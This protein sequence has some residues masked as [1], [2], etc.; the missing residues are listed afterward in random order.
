MATFTKPCFKSNTNPAF[1][2]SRKRLRTGTLTGFTS[3]ILVLFLSSYKRT[4]PE[5]KSQSPLNLV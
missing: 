5:M 2:P 1:L 3:S 4:P